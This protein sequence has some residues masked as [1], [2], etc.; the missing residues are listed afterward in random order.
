MKSLTALLLSFLVAASVYA[1]AWGDG[2]FE[3]DDALDWVAECT[4]AKSIEPVTLALESVLKGGY[5]EAPQGSAAIAAAEVVAAAIG[6]PSLKFPPELQA[7]VRR[8]PTKKLMQLVPTAQKA[9]ARIND[10]K[11]SEL[12][13]LWAEGKPNNWSAVILELESRLGK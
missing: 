6:K 10:K 4:N 3:N 12:K 1:G 11:L 8:M 2:S 7:W 13:Q 9:L 5:I